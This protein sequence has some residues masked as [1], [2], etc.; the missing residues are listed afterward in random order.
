MEGVNDLSETQFHKSGEWFAASGGEVFLH[1]LRCV[2]AVA[3]TG[4][5]NTIVR[6]ALGGRRIPLSPYAIDVPRR[7]FNA[8]P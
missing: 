5:G 7:R 4:R 3:R 1:R 8:M 2:H 6:S